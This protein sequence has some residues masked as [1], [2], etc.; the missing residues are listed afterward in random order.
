MRVDKRRR[1]ENKTNYSKR[2]KYL[3]SG[4]SRIVFRKTNKYLVAQYVKS[5]EAQ[6]KIVFGM[7]TKNLLKNKWPEKL[8]NSLK[9]LPASYFLGYKIGKRIQ[10]DKL[11]TPIVDFGL[12]RI[13]VG[14]KIQGFIKGLVDSGLK[15]KH[16]EEAFPK[17]E[18]IEGA[19]MKEKLP[20]EEI[21]SSLDNEK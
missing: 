20:F 5:S 15:I 13:I 8:K 1:R 7:S 16:K 2:V 19:H 6:D 21:K 18:R 10:K 9:S 11:E 4:K 12:H 14:S 17:K 3:K